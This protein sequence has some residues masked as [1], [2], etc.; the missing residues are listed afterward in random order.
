[1]ALLPRW[2]KLAW[3]AFPCASMRAVPS[4]ASATTMPSAA[5]SVD[6]S[7]RTIAWAMP[8]TAFGAAPPSMSMIA[9]SSKRLLV[10]VAS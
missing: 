10:S 6:A 7:A 9:P 5:G 1:M 3:A 8:G 2:G 4:P